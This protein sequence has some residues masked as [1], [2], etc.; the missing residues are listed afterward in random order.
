MSQ[1]SELAHR[2]FGEGEAGFVCI[3]VEGEDAAI[4]AVILFICVH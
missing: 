2:I 4:G 3:D 1:C